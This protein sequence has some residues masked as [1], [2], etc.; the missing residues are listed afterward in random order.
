[1]N[2]K[3]KILKKARAKANKKILEVREKKKLLP[4][5]LPN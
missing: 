4:L 3:I 5:P 1:M 2:K